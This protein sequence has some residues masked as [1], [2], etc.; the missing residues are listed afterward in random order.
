MYILFIKNHVYFALFLI[1]FETFSKEFERNCEM[2]EN[3]EE[4]LDSTLNYSTECATLNL[5]LEGDNFEVCSEDDRQLH[6]Q[7]NKFIELVPH[8][9]QIN[10]AERIKDILCSADSPASNINQSLQNLDLN[11][12]NI[13][14][15]QILQS[16]LDYITDLQE[17]AYN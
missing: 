17:K 16:I 10:N 13:S 14:D 9:K 2:S 7:L 8:L 4:K 12:K 11:S 3:I 5:S 1:R 6:E 15:L